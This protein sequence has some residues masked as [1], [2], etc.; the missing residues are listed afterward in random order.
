[1]CSWGNTT[2]SIAPTYIYKIFYMEYAYILY[3][4]SIAITSLTLLIL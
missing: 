1:M 4:I 3:R 2:N